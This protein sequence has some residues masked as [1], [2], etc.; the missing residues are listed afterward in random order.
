MQFARYEF[1]GWRCP[2]ICWVPRAGIICTSTAANTITME[3]Y[4]AIDLRTMF[5]V[6]T[7]WG[8]T[9]RRA[10]SIVCRSPAARATCT[11]Y[12]REVPKHNTPKEVMHSVN[13]T[14]I[15]PSPRYK[16]ET[17]I[18]NFYPFNFGTCA[19]V[20]WKLQMS[21]IVIAHVIDYQ[22]AD[23]DTRSSYRFGMRFSQAGGTLKYHFY[24]DP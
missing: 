14:Q 13:L 5:H 9:Y 15:S 6:P 2:G 20:E 18:S 8:V 17:T 7:S 3:P 22:Q 10:K 12:P 1:S 19:G 4:N 24:Q 23:F 11:V 21:C 16:S